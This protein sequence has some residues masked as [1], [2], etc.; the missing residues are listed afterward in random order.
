M[1][2]G[3]A[4]IRI[5]PSLSEGRRGIKR[6]KEKFNWRLGKTRVSCSEEITFSRSTQKNMVVSPYFAKKKELEKNREF[7]VTSYVLCGKWKVEAFF[8]PPF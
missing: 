2:G 4:R 8:P 6:G 1:R 5:H 7:V 3:I